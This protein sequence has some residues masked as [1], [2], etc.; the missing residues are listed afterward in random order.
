MQVKKR[1]GMMENVSFDK[2]TSRIKYLKDDLIIS[3]ALVSQKVV[4]TIYHGI[5]TEEI[6]DHTANIAANMCTIHPD[7][8]LLAGKILISNLHKN[9]HDD[10]L[11]VVDELYNNYVCENVVCGKNI[12]STRKHNPLIS[13]KLF[14]FVKQ[15]HEAIN[16]FVDY[17]KDYTY[18]FFS[19]RTLERAYLLK[20]NDRIIERPQHMLLRIALGHYMDDLIKIRRMYIDLSI[21]YILPQ[22]QHYI[23]V[24]HLGP[25]VHLV[26]L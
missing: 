15:H 6:D 4:K 12:I 16:A 11:Q 5:S 26:L 25:N 20:I 23:I 18:D 14:N 7:Y 13:K 9:T 21:N 2:I 10:Y 3:P 22:H 1:G 8:N 19:F 24:E 17:K